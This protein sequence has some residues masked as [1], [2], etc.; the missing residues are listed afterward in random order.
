MEEAI[1]ALRKKVSEGMMNSLRLR[2][3]PVGVKL[4]RDPKELDPACEILDEPLTFCQFVTYARVYGR[5]LG[6]TQENL[7]CAIAKGMLGFGDLP[8]GLAKRFATVRTSTAEA[9]E[10]ILKTGLRIEP[11]RFNAAL[12]APLGQISADPDVAL[13]FADGAQ[14]TRL[15]YAATYQTGERLSINTAAECGTCGEGVAAAFMKDKPTVSF[16]CYGTR[17]FALAEDNELIFSFPFRYGPEILRG[18]EM[19]EKGGFKYPIL[20]QLSSPKAPALYRI[21][22]AQPPE[23][24]FINLRKLEEEMKK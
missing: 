18:L 22:E 5:S 6:V 8:A 3:L 17:R 12:V 10:E 11:G 7:V 16:P 19:T 2:T 4:L 15:I 24:Y 9:Y 20:R 23:E 13:I 1:R 21:R 14:M